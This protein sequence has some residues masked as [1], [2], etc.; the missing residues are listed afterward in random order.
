MSDVR[1]RSLVRIGDRTEMT[2]IYICKFEFL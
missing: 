2:N 1:F